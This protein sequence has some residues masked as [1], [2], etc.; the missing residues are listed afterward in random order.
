MK[1]EM[2]R[3]AIQRGFT[4]VE[5]LVVVVV[6]GVIL[7]I[8]VPIINNMV[9]SQA[10][11]TTTH[12][13]GQNIAKSVSIAQQVLR[14]PVSNVGA[15]LPT[16]SAL[17]QIKL[18]DIIIKGADAFPAA[19]TETQKN[20]YARSGLRPITDAIELRDSKYWI[21]GVELKKLSN[22]KPDENPCTSTGLG[23]K[24]GVEL[25]NVPTELVIALFKDRVGNDF[26]TGELKTGPV[27]F[28]AVTGDQTHANVTLVYDL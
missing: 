10:A 21:D 3:S 19:A 11:A 7:A 20:A 12:A 26:P 4:L 9:G 25:A 28:S 6:I 14:V 8:A 22:C 13:V 5:M 15:D 23:T 17:G 16:T 2:V 18:L 1:K 24:L 27:R